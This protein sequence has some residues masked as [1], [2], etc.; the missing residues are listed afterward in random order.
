MRLISDCDLGQSQSEATSSP[1]LNS[2]TIHKNS[3]GALNREPFADV[4]S[5]RV[6]GEP[7]ERELTVRSD[8]RL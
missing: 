5:L 8:V 4:E 2:P 1:G 3:R 6:G 7:H